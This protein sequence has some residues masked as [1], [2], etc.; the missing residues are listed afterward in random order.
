[1]YVLSP[2]GHRGWQLKRFRFGRYGRK[3]ERRIVYEE[4]LVLDRY[5]SQYRY[6]HGSGSASSGSGLKAE[7]VC[8]FGGFVAMHGSR[9]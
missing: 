6:A 7:H 4:K 3:I 9:A 1:M 2:A 8:V 5:C